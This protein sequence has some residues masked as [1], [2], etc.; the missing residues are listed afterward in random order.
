MQLG[1]FGTAVAEPAVHSVNVTGAAAK[2]RLFVWA[3]TLLADKT[4]PN[5]AVVS[6]Q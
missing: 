1:C 6:S 4:P 5:L 3:K 2:M